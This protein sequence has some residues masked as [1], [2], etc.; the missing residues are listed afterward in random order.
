MSKTWEGSMDEDLE[1]ELELEALELVEECARHVIDYEKAKNSKAR[2]TAFDG[3]LRNLHSIK[4]AFAMLSCEEIVDQV[5]L[6]ES[7]LIRLKSEQQFG[8]RDVSQLLDDLDLIASYLSDK[9]KKLHFRIRKQ[10]NTEPMRSLG[11]PLSGLDSDH[12]FSRVGKNGFVLKDEG[13]QTTRSVVVVR[14]SV[15]SVIF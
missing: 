5:H 12:R 10:S 6:L 1:K 7:E 11:N 8:S 3:S 15:F 14:M 4:G 9:K 2:Q 13:K